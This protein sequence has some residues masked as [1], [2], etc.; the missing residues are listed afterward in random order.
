MCSGD[1][2]KVIR[3]ACLLQDS[4]ESGNVSEYE[5]MLDARAGTGFQIVRNGL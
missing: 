5:R 4:D 3:K 2:S 1:R